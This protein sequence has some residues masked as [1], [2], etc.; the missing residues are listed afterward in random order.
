MLA[1]TTK[2]IEKYNLSSKMGISD[3]SQYTSEFLENLTDDK[4]QNQARRRLQDGLKF[5]SEQVGVLIPN[6]RSRKNK[7]INLVEGN[8]KIAI[9]KPQKSLEEEIVKEKA[10][11]ILQNRYGFSEDQVNALFT[12]LKNESR[13]SVT[14]SDKNVNI[15]IAN[16]LSKGMEEET[17]RDMAQQ[18]LQDKLS[19]R[20]VRAKAYALALLAKNANAGSSRLTCLCRELKNLNA[21]LEIIEIT[22]FPDITED[23][24]K[25]QSINQK[26]TEAKHINYSD[27]FILESVK[28]KLDT[29]NIKTLSDYQALADVMM[30][31][32][33]RPAELKLYALQ[34]L[35]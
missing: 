24:N 25:I 2:I 23:A 6:Q 14:T 28:E 10:K 5:S 1:I 31:L 11:Q 15:V 18:I 7:T 20:N 30:M 17:I 22:K 8:C 21:S 9:T 13:H 12:I 34:I 33:I 19:I 4:K 3:F 16:Q 29:Y 26:K 27:E 35:K 32:C